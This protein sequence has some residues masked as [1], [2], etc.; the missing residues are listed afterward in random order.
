MPEPFS[1]A[2]GSQQRLCQQ[3]LRGALR[4]ERLPGGGSKLLPPSGWDLLQCPGEL[5]HR[6]PSLW[7]RGGSPGNAGASSAGSPSTAGSGFGAT[8]GASCSGGCVPGEGLRPCGTMTRRILGTVAVPVSPTAVPGWP[9][10]PARRGALLGP[11][12]P[13]SCCAS[14]QPDKMR[15]G[16]LRL[17]GLSGRDHLPDPTRSVLPDL[18]LRHNAYLLPGKALR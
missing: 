3:A 7:R 4:G 12:A 16:R 2:G 15:G 13:G 18:C 17:D 6:A 14:C 10:V 11:T 8:G 1:T 5:C 9:A